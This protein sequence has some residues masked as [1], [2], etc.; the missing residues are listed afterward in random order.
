MKNI[1]Y[2]YDEKYEIID[3][4]IQTTVLYEHFATKYFT[5]KFPHTQI[6]FW[7]K[8]KDIDVGIPLIITLSLNT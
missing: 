3:L 5:S 4:F 6:L 8:L 7:H 1:I 2:Y